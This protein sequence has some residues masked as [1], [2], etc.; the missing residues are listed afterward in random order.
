MPRA[1]AGERAHLGVEPVVLGLA[2]VAQRAS[3]V[4]DHLALAQLSAVALLAVAPL[5]A[6]LLRELLEVHD[7]FVERLASGRAR[8]AQAL[9]LLVRLRLAGE[10]LAH[11][12]R[13]GP[14]GGRAAL[15]D[16][17]VGERRI[18]V[19]PA[20]S[21]RG[22]HLLESSNGRVDELGRRSQA[23]QE[24]VEEAVQDRARIRHRVALPRLPVGVDHAAA[25]RGDGQVAVDPVVE[26]QRRVVDCLES[27]EPLLRLDV[28][29]LEGLR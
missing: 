22:R 7:V 24:E 3:V 21:E 19:G 5:P 4:I 18:E 11:V 6:G 17:L 27:G 13:A 16:Q 28:P 9:L 12:A 26:V 29:A 23:V 10:H 15:D 1:V 14:R 2:H 25:K 20:V 8:R